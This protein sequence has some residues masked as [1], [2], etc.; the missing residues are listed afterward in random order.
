MTAPGTK[1]RR[2][3]GARHPRRWVR[4]LPLG[5][6]AGLLSAA[7]A[8]QAPAGASESLPDPLAAGWNGAPVCEKLHDDAEQRVL[9]CA[10]PP[11]VGHE[12]HFHERHFGYAISGGRMRIT[13]ARGTREVDLATGSSFASEGVAWHEV[14]NV[15]DTTVVY[16]IVEPK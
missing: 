1:G 2:A 12:R 8:A 11:G 16:L 5:V 4:S 9:R 3:M 7:A 14:F 15:G 10:F 6:A 13:D